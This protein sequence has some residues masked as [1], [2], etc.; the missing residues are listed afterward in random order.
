MTDNEMNNME[1]DIIIF[2]DEGF[3]GKNTKR[4]NFQ[5]MVQL[6]RENKIE[7]GPVPPVYCIWQSFSCN[8]WD[9]DLY[10][11]VF[12]KQYG[13]SHMGSLYLY[14]C[15]DALHTYQYPLWSLSG[16]HDGGFRAAE[17]D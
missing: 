7:M 10:Q 15:R 8:I 14:H 1:E 16:C 5:R 9:I 12:R 3:S 4:P 6:C 13:R 17:Q 11:S 2:E